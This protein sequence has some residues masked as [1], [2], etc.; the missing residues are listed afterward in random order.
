MR[1]S[2]SQI[3]KYGTPSFLALGLIAVSLVGTAQ[4]QT[5]KTLTTEEDFN[6]ATTELSNWN[7]W[8]KDDELG[9]ANFIT[10]AKR[11]QAA[12]LVKEGV[13]VSLA[14]DIFQEEVPDGRGHLERKVVGARAGGASD[15]YAFAGT[16]HGSIYSH[17]DAVNCHQMKNGKGYNGR[18]LEDVQAADGCP[19]GGIIALKDGVVTRGVLFDATQLPGKAPKGWLEPGTPVH[20]EDLLTLEKMEHVK[21]SEGDVILLYTGRWKH[22]AAEG[23]WKASEGGA[24]WHADVA[25][26]L[27]ERGVSFIG[28]DQINDVSPTG[29]PQSVGL[30]IHQLAL[31]FLGV[32]IFDNLDFE[33]AVEMARRLNRYE[34]MF[35]A[36]PLRIDKG[37][38][39]PLNPL[40][41]F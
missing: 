9:A 38:G 22:R 16:Y 32:D 7:R 1:H 6:R 34:F 2:I 33:R 17:L 35:S 19:K 40:A 8:G 20:R 37:M 21:V 5:R 30:P 31:A 28:A 39:S 23:P 26:F 13:A 27:K 18:T 29:F 4:V 12:A 11:R 41:I 15:Q 25:Y 24:G 3:I 36:A 10:P 14:H